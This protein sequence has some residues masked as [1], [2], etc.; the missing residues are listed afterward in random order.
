MAASF[1]P[2]TLD[3][4]RALEEVEIE[5]RAGE[6]APWH[7][8]IIWVMVDDADRVFVRSVRGPAA[9][10][11]REAVANPACVLH[12]NELAISALTVAATDGEQVE[13]CSRVLRTKYGRGP[14]VVAMLRPE[15]LPTTL[16]LE[17][18]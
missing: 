10:W 11:Y 12:A 6:G 15:V 4:L 7:R 8:V 1:D 5:T 9:R 14:S 16:R 18:R 2:A 13:S 17:P 3:L